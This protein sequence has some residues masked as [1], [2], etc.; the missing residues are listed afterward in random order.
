VAPLIECQSLAVWTDGRALWVEFGRAD[1]VGV[2]SFRLVGADAEGLFAA[3]L[4][5]GWEV[6]RRAVDA[7]EV[8]N[9]I[10]QQGWKADAE[11]PDGRTLEQ[12]VT[13]ITGGAL[14]G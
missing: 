1:H 14:N 5:E 11:L 2:A 7:L 4:E 8:C 9:T 6:F 12:A 10:A 13:E 3:A